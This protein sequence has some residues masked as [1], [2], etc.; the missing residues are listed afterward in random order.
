MW[1]VCFCSWRAVHNE[2]S[3][4]RHDPYEG[5][6]ERTL[7][8]CTL[9]KSTVSISLCLAS[10]N[11]DQP[12]SAC[13]NPPPSPYHHH[14]IIIT[15]STLKTYFLLQNRHSN[16]YLM[17]LITQ[18]NLNEAKRGSVGNDGADSFRFTSSI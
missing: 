17:Y 6:A 1:P 15:P 7:K 10:S 5:Q 13:N 2:T 9:L 8:S 12:T 18:I 3:K 11:E 14:H 16:L 4:A